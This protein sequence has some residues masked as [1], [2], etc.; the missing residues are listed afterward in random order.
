LALKKI[1]ERKKCRAIG[2]LKLLVSSSIERNNQIFGEA[3]EGLSKVKLRSTLTGK[4]CGQH[5]EVQVAACLQ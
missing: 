3:Q 2:R 5:K 4:K 1:Y